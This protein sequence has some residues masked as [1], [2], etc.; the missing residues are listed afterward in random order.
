V[1]DF[2][3]RVFQHLDRP[4]LPFST[5]F[6]A[7]IPVNIAI[8]VPAVSALFLSFNCWVLIV[9]KEMVTPR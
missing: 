6:R 8:T 7:Q 5:E 1:T 9:V 4:G 2:L 3:A